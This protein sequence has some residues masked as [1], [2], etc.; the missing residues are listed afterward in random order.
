MTTIAEQA[1]IAIKN[2]QLYREQENLAISSIKSLF[3]S[4]VTTR[5]N[6]PYCPK[7]RRTA[8]NLT[9]TM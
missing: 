5:R 7:I 4:P 3:P 2:A 8:T 1:V 9:D 6:S